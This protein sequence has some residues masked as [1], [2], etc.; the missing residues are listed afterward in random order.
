[1]FPLQNNCTHN[2]KNCYRMGKGIDLYHKATI[3][4]HYTKGTFW[5]LQSSVFR[6]VILI[7]TLQL[8][9][10]VGANYIDKGL[11]FKISKENLDSQ[12]NNESN[13]R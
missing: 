13:N 2:F 7:S 6:G 8:K 1:M 4:K 9:L 10:D 12:Q 11:K 3:P 5:S